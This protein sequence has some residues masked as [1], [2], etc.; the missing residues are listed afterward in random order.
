MRAKAMTIG[1]F[2]AV[3]NLAEI[4]RRLH[5]A[6]M[7]ELVL[8][9]ML[10]VRQEFPPAPKID[11]VA[12]VR[13]ELER[14]TPNLKKGSKIAVAAGSR[15]ISNLSQIVK[16]TIDWLKDHGAR[17][18]IVPAMGSHGG[19]TPKGQTELLAEAG[20]NS[21]AMG[22][23]VHAAMEVECIGQTEDAVDVFCSKEA[24]A[25]DGVV[26][27]NRVKPHT[28][29]GGSLGSGILKMLV[30]GLGKRAGA[31]NFHIL[32]S[33]FGYEHVI[34]TSSRVTLRK[35]PVLCGLAV[36][37][38][39]RHATARIAA[40]RPQELEARESELFAESARLMPRL[41]FEEIDLLIVDE[42]GKNI[43]GAGMD[44]NVIGRGVHGYSSLLSDHS[45]KPVIRRLL[46]RDLTP[47]THGNAIGIGMAD[48]TTIR[49]AKGM[50]QRVTAINALTSLS[51]LSAKI[52]IQFQTDREAIDRALDTLD[53]RDRREAKVMRIRNTLA[54]ETLQISEAFREPFPRQLAIVSKPKQ[55][56][57]DRKGN[58]LPLQ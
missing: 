1:F 41:P 27:I 25:A 6:L 42:L 2:G 55:I 11:V 38:D 32:A 36:I 52:P 18:Y 51:V 20:I 10:T 37:E 35:L 50:D 53:L 9:R 17:P 12:V 40:V 5:I 34:R 58:L 19:A 56:E 46:V 54:L 3:Q 30:V 21:R 22:A 24:L 15:G 16:A 39:Q 43:S 13:S 57:F 45:T 23:P 33:R 29:F 31:A 7:P 49:L 28:D 26:V 4:G 47:E 8:P 44:P 48:F 14:V